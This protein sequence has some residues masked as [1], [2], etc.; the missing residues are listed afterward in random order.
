MKKLVLLL[1]AIIIVSCSSDSAEPKINNQP[2]DEEIA[3]EEN[4]E[5]KISFD[6]SIFTLTNGITKEFE[7]LKGELINSENPR[8]LTE[9]MN[10][11]EYYRIKVEGSELIIWDFLNRHVWNYNAMT[12]EEEIFSEYFDLGEDI[13]NPCPVPT[14][15]KIITFFSNEDDPI[16]GE[17]FQAE[18][19]DINLDERFNI[20]LPFNSSNCKSKD[21]IAN[22]NILLYLF[23]EELDNFWG[24]IDVEKKEFV[25]RVPLLDTSSSFAL[26]ERKIIFFVGVGS[27]DW[28]FRIYDID[29]KDYIQTTTI[30]DSPNSSNTEIW[31]LSLSTYWNRAQIVNDK[32]LFLNF[33]SGRSII[34]FGNIDQTLGPA[35]LDLQSGELRTFSAQKMYEEYFDLDLGRL[36]LAP[37][38][39]EID[40][41][42][43]IIIITYNDH[44]Y[45]ASPYGVLFFDFELNLIKNI[46][47]GNEKPIEMIKY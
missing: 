32:M 27:D 33:P 15:E 8:N 10:L 38:H 46:E 31:N 29:A 39:T 4:E 30:F 28:A 23:S 42:S 13:R 34:P 16:V 12:K 35:I 25:D 37:I 36:N 9:I 45:E 41:E 14:D 43:E 26:D 17:Q 5:E 40:L 3:E 7:I 2:D 11:P 44:T 24:I 20:E 1:S 21:K 47:L 19:Y 18:I 22:N 6:I